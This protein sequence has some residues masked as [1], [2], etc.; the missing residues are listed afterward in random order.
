M[1]KQDNPQP[2]YIVSACLVGLC[3][4][5]DGSIKANDKCRY[6]LNDAAWIPVCPEQLG[7]L[8]TPREA[9]NI[10]GGQGE[11]VLSGK[12]Q[13][14]TMSGINVTE[15]FIRGA[16]QVLA[17][18]RSQPVLAILL[19]ARSPSCGVSGL[20]GVTAAL[21]KQHGFLLKEF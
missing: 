1:T 8:P 3:T 21:L 9:A 12:A 20:T 19:K 4:R 6:W 10:V 17:I 2:F 5:Y 7:G 18:A 15:Q 11:D 14:V 13:V 16:H